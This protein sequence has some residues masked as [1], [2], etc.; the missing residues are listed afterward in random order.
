MEKTREPQEAYKLIPFEEQCQL[1]EGVVRPG[2]FR[3]GLIAIRSS[4]LLEKISDIKGDFTSDPLWFART[5]F[6]LS[7]NIIPELGETSQR[8]HERLF[9]Y[10][11]EEKGVN[12]DRVLVVADHEGDDTIRH[13][14][15]HDVLFSRPRDERERLVHYIYRGVQK[16]FD[17]DLG[18]HMF[19]VGEIFYP[20]REMNGRLGAVYE[21]T[22]K[23]FARQWGNTGDKYER[24]RTESAVYVRD[25]APD[26]LKNMYEEMGFIW[27]SN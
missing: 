4:E 8:F 27:L 11:K 16:K 26:G 13:E 22:C 10:L 3:E 19:R 21:F 7:R 25:N 9:E 12:A 20:G 24:D 6:Y 17:K 18:Y 1:L 2:F 23:F 14:L 15:I 5:G